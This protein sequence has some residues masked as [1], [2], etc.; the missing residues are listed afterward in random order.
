MAAKLKP[1]LVLVAT[2]VKSPLLFLKVVDVNPEFFTRIKHRRFS[3]ALAGHTSKIVKPSNFLE[4]TGTV[5]NGANQCGRI[6]L[7]PNV[8]LWIPESNMLQ[9]AAVFR[10]LSS[11]VVAPERF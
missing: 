9:G 6:P 7:D 3:T 1:D 5:N 8:G 4:G 2:S 10:F 11:V